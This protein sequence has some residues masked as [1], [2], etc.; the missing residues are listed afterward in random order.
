[1][2]ILGAIR[3][4]ARE[5]EELLDGVVD[6]LAQ[7][8]RVDAIPQRQQLRLVW[9]QH[10]L[11]PA[12]AIERG[13]GIVIV[14]DDAGR[15]PFLTDHLFLGEVHHRLEEIV[16]DPQLLIQGIERQGL[17][18]RVKPFIAE[19]GAHQGGVFLLNAR[20]IIL[21]WCMLVSI[22]RRGNHN[23]KEDFISI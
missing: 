21:A 15:L 22:P 1:M 6:P 20:V 8:A 18:D 3:S 23:L 2:D 7:A 16:V 13:G 19:K 4:R 5:L 14:A 9:G 11:G 10:T 12:Q 17:G